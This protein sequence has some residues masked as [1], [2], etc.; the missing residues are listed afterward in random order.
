MSKTIDYA[1]VVH[2]L[3]SAMI[4][5]DADGKILYCNRSAETV[6]DLDVTDD[7]NVFWM[8]PEAHWNELLREGKTEVSRDGVP[9]SFSLRRD[10][11]CYIL[12]GNITVEVYTARRELSRKRGQTSELSVLFDIYID[13]RIWIT[14]GTGKTLF[15]SATVA[16]RHGVPQEE[17]VGRY[18]QDLE[19]EKFFSPSVTL[20]VLRTQRQS[21]VLQQLREGMLCVAVGIPIF[22]SDGSIQRVIS[23]TRD[24][25]SQIELGDALIRNTGG[26]ASTAPDDIFGSRFI[27]QNAEMDKVLKL[28]KLVAPTDSTILIEGESGVGKS[29]L[30]KLIHEASRRASGPF[31][32]INC[33]VIAENL[34]EAE[35]FGYAPG[36]FT[37]ADAQGKI[38]LIE[39]A[40]GGTL[41]LD[42][43][44]EMSLSQQ[45]KLLEVIQG[46]CVKRV[47]STD[48]IDVDVRIVCASKSKLADLVAA[49]KF[50]MDLFYRLNVV[51][52]HL[53]PLRNRKEDIPH[54]VRHIATRINKDY[55]LKKSFSPAALD[56]LCLYEYPGNVR[57]LAHAVEQAMVT[58]AGRRID[59]PDLPEK[60][61]Q[62]FGQG[63]QENDWDDVMV[64]DIMP[65]DTALEQTERQLLQLALEKYGMKEEIATA[66]GIGKA[67][68]W[69]KL[70]KYGLLR[71]TREKTV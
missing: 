12:S 16:S 30:A 14:D 55:G 29:H 71:E 49:S 50:R 67:T 40:N 5:C 25:T 34:F 57:E 53:P 61:R 59:V 32:T 8:M 42:E 36:S 63:R 64:P 60:V 15:V 70:R 46:R 28:A 6:F 51:T 37:G 35:L 43:I 1:A 7:V 4:V 48:P 52:L 21:V 39:A 41:F 20:E 2:N 44:E 47:G 23:I 45:V 22:G 66:L 3:P 13:E 9:I 33:A 65:L 69:R 27:T 68:L 11:K 56:I 62:A 24:C 58:T 38:G 54:L 31:L 10:G 17:L 18:V 26:A 19:R